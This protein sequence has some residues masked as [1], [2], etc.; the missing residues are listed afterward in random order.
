MK[1]ATL[2]KITLGTLEPRLRKP[3]ARSLKH[4]IAFFDLLSPFT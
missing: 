3:N 1:E 4:E 2:P